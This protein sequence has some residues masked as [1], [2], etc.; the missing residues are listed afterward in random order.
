MYHVC[1]KL[2]RRPP[3]S[4]RNDPASFV[5]ERDLPHEKGNS[6]YPLHKPHN[7]EELQG[8]TQQYILYNNCLFI[9]FI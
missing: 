8:I 1:R 2:L 7:Q 6:S 4:C 5:N 3:P 9:Y